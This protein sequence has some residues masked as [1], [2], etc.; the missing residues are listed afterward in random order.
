[1]PRRLAVM[2]C[3]CLAL[4]G[5]GSKNSSFNP[6][7]GEVFVDGRPATGATVIFH[8]QGQPDAKSYPSAVVGPDGRY[9][10]TTLK[11]DDGAPE[12]EYAVTVVWPGPKPEGAEK[13]D[14][15][16]DRLGGAYANPAGSTLKAH[17]KKGKNQVPRFDLREVAIRQ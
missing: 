2:T 12:G 11:K 6:T 13:D 5:C 1:M 7:T 4:A 8:P 14:E 9:T 15:A 3:L 17:V 10:L 16:P